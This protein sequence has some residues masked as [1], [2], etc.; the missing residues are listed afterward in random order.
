MC[1]G[2]RMNEGRWLF[3]NHFRQL[4]K[5]VVFFEAVEAVSKMGLSLKQS[6]HDQ[7]KLVQINITQCY[8]FLVEIEGFTNEICNLTILNILTKLVFVFVTNLM[9]SKCWEEKEKSFKWLWKEKK[10]S[11]FRKSFNFFL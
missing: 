8:C 6:H 5:W 11:S 10:I 9:M 3:L 7:V 4:L 2:F 1:Q